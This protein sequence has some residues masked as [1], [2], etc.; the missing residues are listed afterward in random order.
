MILSRRNF[1]LE[2]IVFVDGQA[3]CGKTLLSPIVAAMPRVELLSYMTDVENT[4][5]LNYLSKIDRDAA[6]AM[7]G[8]QTDLKIY[9]TMMGRDVNFR[10]SDLSSAINNINVKKY[11]SR[12][13][14]PGDDKIPA[15]IK[16]ENPIL[17]IATHN[18]LPFSEP[19]WNR[20][21]DRK[22]VFIEVVRHPLYMIRQQY[23]NIKRIIGTS[24]HFSIYYNHN[25]IELPYFAYGI[26]N[27]YIDSNDMERVIYS[28]NNLT[29]IAKNTK[30]KL[31][32]K[33]NI[34]TVPFE[35]FVLNPNPWVE[36]IAKALG[37]E[38]TDATI[39][40]MK[41]Q[42]VPR[43]MVAQGIDLEIYRRC[44]W[45]PPKSGATERDELNIRR[46]DVA[47]EVSSDVLNILDRLSEEYENK[48]WNPDV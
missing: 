30:A 5:I 1:L 19:I 15:I 12:I 23:L 17:N 11:I 16:K 33:S 26:E 46:E 44:G 37:T 32:N 38:V 2:N 34:I 47:R 18:L 21:S 7:I 31:L 48:Y 45:V 24:R 10:F 9:Q 29:V 8:I 40:V 13:F 3:G 42:N 14:E 6:E 22:C 25:G 27:E 35:Q 4:C 36:K 20:L 41:E 28:I 43:D 39:K